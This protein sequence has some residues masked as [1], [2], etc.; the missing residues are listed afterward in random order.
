MTPKV[1]GMGTEV[2]VAPSPLAGIGVALVIITAIIGW[3]A[4]GGHFLSETSPFAGFMIL[5]Y[6]AKVEH[7]AMRRLPAS[8]LGALAGIGIA[9]TMYCGASRYGGAWLASKLPRPATRPTA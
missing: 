9:W 1:N 7:L 2:T 6:W 4:I 8:I 3:A 5:W